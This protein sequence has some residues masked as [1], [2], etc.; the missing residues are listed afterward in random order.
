MQRHQTAVQ[1]LRRTV[2]KTT[3]RV[4]LYSYYEYHFYHRIIYLI[5]KGYGFPQRQ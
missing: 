3:I 1:V 5:L 4:N 2:I